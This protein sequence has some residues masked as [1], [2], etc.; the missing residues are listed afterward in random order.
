MTIHN[1]GAVAPNNL[2]PKRW[3]DDNPIHCVD[4]TSRLYYGGTECDGCDESVCH[5]CRTDIKTDMGPD[6]A[7]I[8]H[9]CKKCWHIVGDA[10]FIQDSKVI[11]A[12]PIA[13]VQNKMTTKKSMPQ[14]KVKVIKPWVGGQYQKLP[15]GDP[16]DVEM[17]PEIFLDFLHH[18]MTTQ[19]VEIAGE[20]VWDE[21][22]EEI[23]WVS[24]IRRAQESPGHV[25]SWAAESTNN[26]L[27]EVGRP[28][29]GQWHT[30][31][32]FSA[33]HSGED[34]TN[35]IEFC[36]DAMAWSKSGY[37]IFIVHN[38]LDWNVSR[39]DWADGK[40]ISRRSGTII[41]SGIRMQFRNEYARH[42]NRQNN[43]QARKKKRRITH[44]QDNVWRPHHGNGATNHT[45]EQL[46][47]PD[48]AESWLRDEDARPDAPEDKDWLYKGWWATEDRHYARLFFMMDIEQY[49]WPELYKAVGVEWGYKHYRAIVDHPDMWQ[50]LKGALKDE[51]A[52]Q[53]AIAVI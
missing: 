38:G 9:W 28:P 34:K 51:R 24:K 30:H 39:I 4:C 27:N 2:P 15:L 22:V 3:D 40:L 10:E 43:K 26:A 6:A 7:Y 19:W 21:E 16:F 45:G 20:F 50:R 31:P 8:S 25:N 42:W 48:E 36:T 1:A 41:V 23:V 33:F 17:R 18:L 37:H 5:A 29:N 11:P 44:T 47:L 53:Q 46:L 35:M 13:K 12:S 14:A 32:G 49:N 52:E